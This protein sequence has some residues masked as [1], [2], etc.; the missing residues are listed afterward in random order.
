M[1]RLPFLAGLRA[2]LARDSQ[3][4]PGG[5]VTL[6]VSARDS[7]PN[8]PVATGTRRLKA[9]C[10][11][12]V[13]EPGL[14]VTRVVGPSPAAVADATNIARSAVASA[15]RVIHR[16]ITSP[17]IIDDRRGKGSSSR[18]GAGTPQRDRAPTSQ[19]GA[20]PGR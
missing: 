15:A 17:P 9:K 3:W 14:T 19:T 4:A 5:P 12:A 16:R 18:V 7:V 1:T 13:P 11:R 8:L 20:A 2:R 10:V 6:S